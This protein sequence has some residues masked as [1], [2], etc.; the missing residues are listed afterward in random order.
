MTKIAKYLLSMHYVT[1]EALVIVA[2]FNSFS[3][4][5]P[6]INV[7]IA[8]ITTA[9]LDIILKK[10]LLN[11]KPSLPLSAIIT[12]LIIGLVTPFQTNTLAVIIPS[13]LAV[14]SKFFIRLKGTHIF[15]PAVF[16][17]V[18]A[19]LVFSSIASHAPSGA[20]DHMSA[21]ASIGGFAVNL[22]LV[23]LLVYASYTARKLWLAVP[24]LIISGL[25]YVLTGLTTINSV[26]ITLPY[27]FSFIIASEP[28]TTPSSKKQQLIFGV[29]IAIFPFLPFLIGGSYNHIGA[30]LS[31]LIGNL[32]YGIYRTR[33]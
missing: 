12:G 24:N 30:L 21:Q 25:L 9:V 19:I 8:V 16:G 28:K 6:P 4:G 18:T 13:I 23:P 22:I 33:S 2:L 32:V 29:V 31:L 27:F 3:Q 1:I 11:Q 10:V 15:N 20:T 14:L 17:V 7:S 5:N 26:V